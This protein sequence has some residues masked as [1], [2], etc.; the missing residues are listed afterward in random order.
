VSVGD[1]INPLHDKRLT[2]KEKYQKVRDIAKRIEDKA[3][4]KMNYI[5]TNDHADLLSTH[6]RNSAHV[7]TP[8]RSFSRS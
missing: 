3:L 5:K 1:W 4:Q 6:T 8:N 7:N 2:A